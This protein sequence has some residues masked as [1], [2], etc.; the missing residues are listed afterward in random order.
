MRPSITRLRTGLGRMK[1]SEET[2]RRSQA[3]PGFT[4]IELLVVIAIIARPDRACCCRPCRRP[5][6]RPG[7]PSASTTSSRSAWRCTTTRAPTAASRSPARGRCTPGSRS[8]TRCTSTAP[9]IHARILPFLEQTSVFNAINF[10]FAD[11]NHISGVELHGVLARSSTPSSAPAP[12]ATARR[13]PRRHERPQRRAVR[14]RR[15]RA[16]A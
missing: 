7:A 16:T 5:A 10:N 1:R 6:R 9:G 8:P 14:A 4:L 3:A 12:S 15:A 11:Y 13:G 2:S